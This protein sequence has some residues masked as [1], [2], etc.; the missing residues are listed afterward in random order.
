[1]TDTISSWPDLAG[2]ID[3]DTHILPIR[4]YFED[5][6]FT[7]LVY[8]ATYLRWAERGRSDYVRLLGVHHNELENPA[9]GSEPAA[10]VVRHLEIDF[11][12]PAKIDE[13]LEVHTSVAQVGGATLTLSQEIKR[14]DTTLAR[15]K[16]KVVLVSKSGKPRRLGEMLTNILGGNAPA[17]SA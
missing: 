14:E 6:D 17:K 16:V 12:R 15:L 3:G 1:M 11:L 2:R 9:D 4:V 8:H 10:F 13:I 7:G 5:T